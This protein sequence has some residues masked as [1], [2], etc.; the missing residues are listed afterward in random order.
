MI[1]H[2]RFRRSAFTLIELLVVIA[3]IAILVALLL[4][5]V[6]QAREA[7]RRSQC[8]NNLKQLGLALHNYHDVQRVFPPGSIG[9]AFTANAL[10]RVSKFGP[11]VQILPYVDQANL[12]TQVDFGTSFCDPVNAG[13]AK[14]RIVGYFCPSYPGDKSASDQFYQWGS[15]PSGSANPAF[16]AA[17]TN[18]LAVG[19][20][21]PTGQQNFSSRT[22]LGAPERYGIFYS[23][24]NTRIADVTD[25]TSNTMMYGEFRP[26]IMQEITDVDGARYP[27][28]SFNSRWSPWVAGI[29]LEGGGST[30]G[31]RYGPNQLTPKAKPQNQAADWTLLPFS[32]SHPGG[33]HM[34]FADGS[35]NFI[36]DNIDINLWRSLSTR[37][38][39]EVVGER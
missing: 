35:V 33:V 22:S 8:K 30:R 38:G 10:P 24:S 4:P 37:A 5:A 27:T 12:Y 17:I 25:G 7:A 9:T 20:Y 34:L 1:P 32:S 28:W 15:P 11:L 31:T 6:Q 2:L 21:H 14:T 26:S 18:Y 36:S 19:G 29:Y 13:I 23:D 3:I 39:G 16:E